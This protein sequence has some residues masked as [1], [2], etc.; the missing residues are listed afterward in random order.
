MCACV[1]GMVDGGVVGEAEERKCKVCVCNRG[2]QHQSVTHTH[3]TPSH[4]AD[5]LNPTTNI[6]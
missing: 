3:L 5:T 4:S 6:T 2:D 1:T